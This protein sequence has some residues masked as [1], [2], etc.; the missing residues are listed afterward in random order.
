MDIVKIAN[1]WAKAEIL[2][3]QFFV[4]FGILFLV[5]SLGFWQFGR[6]EVAKAFFYPFL[7]TG[8]LLLILG[9]G[10]WFS[11][12]SN[13]NQFESS[14]LKDA[15]AFVQS[16]IERTE[17]TISSYQKVALK[18]FPLFIVAAGLI[19]VL[20]D[21]PLWRAISIATIAMFLVIILIDSNALARMEHYHKQ[22]T[23]FQNQ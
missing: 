1:D 18:V 22:L 12:K 4:L 2:S 9:F 3:N 23:S 14:Y 10:L 15:T 16:E 21:K 19:I 7:I 5:T 8:I 6:T 17:R 20:T 13:M 11:A